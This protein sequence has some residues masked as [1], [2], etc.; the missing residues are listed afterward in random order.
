M[1][2]DVAER[3]EGPVDV[4][5]QHA[6]AIDDDPLHRAGRQLGGR[7]DRHEAFEHAALALEPRA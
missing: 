5:D 6:L 1:A 7:G 3:V 4:R 2:A